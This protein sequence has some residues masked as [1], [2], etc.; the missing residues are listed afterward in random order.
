M[1]MLRAAALMAVT[2][3]TG[4]LVAPTHAQTSAR[5]SAEQ[6]LS[7][8]RA[9]L[10]QY[11]SDLAFVLA[12]EETTQRITRQTPVVQGAPTSRRTKAEVYFKY[13]DVDNTW[14]AI[15]EFVQI[16]GRTVE[17]HPDLK[18]ALQSQGLAQVART[19]KA[20]NSQFNIGRIYRNFNEPTLALGVLEL[21]R[22][23]QFVFTHKGTRRTNGPVLTTLAFRDQPGPEAFVYNLDMQPAAVEGEI[24]IEQ[25]TGR[26]Y[27]TVLNIQM[28]S[29][30]AV[31]TT[32]YTRQ[33][34]VNL[35]VPTV[36][37]EQ[38]EAGVDHSGSAVLN[39]AGQY[40]SIFCDSRYTNFRQFKTMSRI[41]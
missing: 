19:F 26:I 10:E 21:D 40:E 30:K 18:A 11:R 22:G 38:Y 8:A 3:A 13:V 39:F 20:F 32:E 33:A 24:L 31:L 37:R 25:G 41:K 5:P 35:L 15:R 17:S 4:S 34:S 7:E 27:R 28:E 23:S 9:Y 12:D 16:D 6:T 1:T 29:V 36:F 2:A 14:M